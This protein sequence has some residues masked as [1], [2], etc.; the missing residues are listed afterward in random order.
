MS[1]APN[2]RPSEPSPAFED[3]AALEAAIEKALRPP[4]AVKPPR[5]RRPSPLRDDFRAEP[6]WPRGQWQKELARAI[7][8]PR[9]LLTALG[10][11]ALP[12]D[13]AASHGF[14]LR[15]P[16]GFVA[17]MRGGDRNDPLLLQVLPR[18]EETLA[19]AGFT[20]DPVGELAGAHDGT[21]GVLRKYPG[22]ALLVVT[23]ACAVHCRYCF[24]RHFPYADHR[25]AV[26]PEPAL[27][28]LAE[29]PSVREVILSGGDP[30]TVPDELLAPLVEKLGRIPHLET[31]RI[32][33][34]T[35]VVLPERVDEA[36]LEW[37]DRTPLQVVVVLHANH[38]HELSPRVA[39]ALE[40]LRA[41][42]ITLLNQAVLLRGINDEVE[43]QKR[44][45]E[46]LLE[47]GVQPYYLHLLDRV[48][49]AAHFEVPRQEAR[50]LEARL[51]ATVPGY[52]VPRFVY[53]EEGAAS[54]TALGPGF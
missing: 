11:E 7:K 18:Q 20:I 52:L 8:N 6:S 12:E 54:K 25:L 53:E 26:D 28:A 19:V 49:G 2:H 4:E 27:E 13:T 22:R 3:D 48:Q 15:V 42:G 37:V 51:R 43:T 10:L 46:R 47:V 29:T 34:R 44:L 40:P 36:L 9:E 38:P 32:H 16:W 17:Q 35:P 39:R 23:G 24:R 41:R 31:L 50:A 5:V 30:L 45:S 1:T 14:P 33:T 21:P